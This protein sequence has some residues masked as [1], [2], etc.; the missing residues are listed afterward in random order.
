MGFGWGKLYVKIMHKIFK[1]RRKSSQSAMFTT[2]R[3]RSH[4]VK[5]KVSFEFR[6]EKE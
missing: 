2:R 5:E 3:K 4:C 6:V 1:R